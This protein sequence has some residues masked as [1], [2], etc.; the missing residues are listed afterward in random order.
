M[1]PQGLGGGPIHS[2]LSS[3]GQIA[4]WT[5]NIVLGETEEDLLLPPDI[6]SVAQRS[7][8]TIG[9][10]DYEL[11]IPSAVVSNV[12]GSY[13]PGMFG[14]AARLPLASPSSLSAIP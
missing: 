2:A 9:G 1:L 3:R 14:Y 6:P 12:N 8:N 5:D 10:S 11:R 4:P 7:S 13:Q